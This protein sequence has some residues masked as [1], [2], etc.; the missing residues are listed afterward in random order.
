MSVET[1]DMAA[2]SAAET[3]IAALDAALRTA[4]G[5]SIGESRRRHEMPEWDVAAASIAE[6]GA[7]LKGEQGF[8][9]LVMISTV[10]RLTHLDVVYFLD[11]MP[12]PPAYKRL[13]LRVKLEREEP[14]LPSVAGIWRAANWHE[15]EAYDLMGVVFEGHPDLR[16]ILLPDVWEGHPLRKDYRY[17]SNTMVD[18]I[19]AAELGPDEAARRA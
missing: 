10:D 7:W 18:E 1:L 4:F 13:I 9:H 17:D 3:E 12:Q 16:R 14:K 15:R 5:E 6:V 19:L 8:N 11:K 2:P